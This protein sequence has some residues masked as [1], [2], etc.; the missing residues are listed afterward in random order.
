MNQNPT[1]TPA[2]TTLVEAM[3]Q[4]YGQLA[5]ILDHMQRN[6]DE[7]PDAASIPEVLAELLG[8]V[9][10]Q[11]RERHGDEAVATAAQM[12]SAATQLIGEEVFLVD[13]AGL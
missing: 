2:V 12:L 11:L 4:S 10:A 8:G 1:P 5:L 7:S 3:L 13:P 9:L 6:R